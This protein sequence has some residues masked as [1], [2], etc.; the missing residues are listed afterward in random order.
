MGAITTLAQ[1]AKLEG[2]AG[3][4]DVE[5]AADMPAIVGHMLK[6]KGIGS[7]HCETTFPSVQKEMVENQVEDHNISMG[8]A[9]TFLGRRSTP[10]LG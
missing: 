9:A 4:I 8:A 10:P 7:K 6:L 3:G 2:G 1:A 5:A